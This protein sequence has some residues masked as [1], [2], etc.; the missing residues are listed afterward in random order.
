[1]TSYWAFCLKYRTQVYLGRGSESSRS[2]FSWGLRSIFGELHL[3]QD[4]V[5]NTGLTSVTECWLPPRGISEY[6]SVSVIEI[7]FP[8][9]TSSNLPFHPDKIRIQ[10]Y[11]ELFHRS[12]F[13]KS[14]IRSAASQSLCR[15]INT[16]KWKRKRHL[17]LQCHAI[18][19]MQF[20]QC[21]D[22]GEVLVSRN[23][24]TKMVDGDRGQSA[25]LVKLG[26]TESLNRKKHWP[27][28]LEQQY[29]KCRGN[30][31]SSR[32]APRARDLVELDDA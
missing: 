31:S 1:M 6:S 14:V 27:L 25:Y 11:S 13:K 23:V 8:I 26:W 30:L 17:F 28:E 32:V 12:I 7:C 5:R 16:Q 22:S 3:G 21:V 9:T 19:V 29:K 2:P 10:N 15:G 20:W 24:V 4:Q 18:S